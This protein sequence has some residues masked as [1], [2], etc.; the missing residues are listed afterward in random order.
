MFGKL[1]RIE[2]G[3][4]HVAID[5]HVEYPATTGDQ[6]CIDSKNSIDFVRQTGGLRF[7]VS[8][9]AVVNFDFHFISPF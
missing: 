7:V 3:V 9:C 2:L 8:F 4:D 1:A 5:Y 6:S